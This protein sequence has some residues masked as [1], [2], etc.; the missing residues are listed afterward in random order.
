MRTAASP[1]AIGEPPMAQLVPFPHRGTTTPA[2]SA[3]DF[4]AEHI[5]ARTA[6][7]LRERFAAEGMDIEAPQLPVDVIRVLCREIEELVGGLFI[8]RVGSD[9][10]PPNP[11]AGIDF[12]AAMEVKALLESLTR[13]A[14]EHLTPRN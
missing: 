12:E 7:Y 6:A 8:M 4:T 11:Q 10:V 5:R 9:T 3:A 1:D 14:E 13:A 2:K